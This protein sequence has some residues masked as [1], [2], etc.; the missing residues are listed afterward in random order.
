MNPSLENGAVFAGFRIIRQLGSGG[1]GEVYLADHPRLPRQEALK[2]LSRSFASDAEYQKRFRQEAELAAA[3]WHPNL[4]AL[5]DRGEADGR[6]WISMDYIDGLDTAELIRTQH[7]AGIPVQHVTEIVTAVASAL[8]YAHQSGMLHRDVK[9]AN[10]LCGH[11]RPGGQR[12]ALADFGIARAISDPSGLT[13]TNMTVGTVAYAAPEQLL[14]EAIDGRADQY[15][16]AATAFHLLTG[17]APYQSTNPV[18][19]ISQHLT[20][21]PPKLSDLRPELVALDNVF[22][23]ALD[24]NPDRRYLDC[25]AFA[26]DFARNALG[27]PIAAEATLAALPAATLADAAPTQAGEFPGAVPSSSSSDSQPYDAIAKRRAV[28]IAGGVAAAVAIVGGTW[29][30]SRLS[31]DHHS[32][33]PGSFLTGVERPSAAPAP[34]PRTAQTAAEAIQAAIPEVTTLIALTEDNDTNNLI[35]RPNG[36]VAAT[37]LVDSR[38]SNVN[39]CSIADA[40]VDCGATVEQWPDENAAQKRAE[41]IQQVRATVP[42]VG[43]EWTTVKDSLVLRVTGELKPSDAEAYKTAFIGSANT[44]DMA[45]NSKEALEAAAHRLDMLAAQGDAAGAYALYSQRCKLIIGNLE[46]FRSILEIFFKDRNPKYVSATANIN[47]SHGQVVS[48]DEDPSAP[49]D[50]MNPRTWTFI[51]GRWQFDN[52]SQSI[53]PK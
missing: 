25:D 19:V 32:G 4:V 36:Y 34:G 50:S 45:P 52:C 18:A 14:G 43:Q 13:A 17:S 33:E 38:I 16:L 8:D 3:L 21:T 29:T 39:P 24:K 26:R 47:G 7:P 37:V 40:G 44:T 23:K 27:A 12:I 22:E 30:V 1:M 49:A 20:A 42:L 2:I 51:D 35:G 41:Y 10:I 11:P 6:L 46:D 53:W 31:A 28:W 48:I 5:H 15:A 9:P